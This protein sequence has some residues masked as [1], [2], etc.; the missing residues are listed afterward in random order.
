MYKSLVLLSLMLISS[1][2][3]ANSSERLQE[4]AFTDQTEL[5]QVTL[6]RKNQSVLTYLWVDV[7]AAA[8]YAEPGVS[9]R[10]A[11][12][13]QRSKRLELYYFRDIDRTDVVKA[14]WVTLER[15]HDSAALDR[16]RGDI[17]A[18]H[19]QFRDIRAQDRYALNYTDDGT[20]SL[21]R[22]GEV[23]FKSTNRELAQA[24]LGIWLAADGLSEELRGRLLAD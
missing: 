23:V 18:L 5:M 9:A 8:L 16:L 1:G 19:A 22:N 10:R 3:M 15:Q 12:D 2:L 11:L 4:A 20:L 17:D 6:E 14:A 7:Y 24:Y 21:E 13:D